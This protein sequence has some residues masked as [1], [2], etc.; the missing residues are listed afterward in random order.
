MRRDLQARRDLGR[1]LDDTFA[2]YREHWRTVVPATAAI[3]AP[4][5]LGVFGIGLGW[6]W[7]G[8]D[9]VRSVGEAFVAAATQFGLTTPLVTAIAIH[10]AVEGE[11][12]R[13]PGVGP[14]VNFALEAFRALFPAMLIVALGV[15]AGLLAAIVPGIFLAV[16]WAVVPQTVVIEGRRTDDAL[17][18]SWNRVAGRGWW[19]FVVI[20]VANLLV[21]ALSAVFLVPADLIASA[22]DAQAVSLAGS[23]LAQIATL[24]LA[25]FATTLLYFSLVA[26]PDAPPP[27]EPPP[28]EPDPEAEP[29]P[30]RVDPITS[31][32]IP[33]PWERRRRE[34]WEPPA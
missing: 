24:P 31:E 20:L 25:G 30:E 1:I 9:S 4:I 10:A 29:E 32:P 27:T 16:R 15:G 12:G 18:S 2:L 7:E 33:D 5:Q 22:V 14:A 28:V 3:V 6:L 34:G 17:R 19:T 8:Y 13:R 23:M 11:V 26:G 21:G